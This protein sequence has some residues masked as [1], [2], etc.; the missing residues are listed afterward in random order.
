MCP[1]TG[2]SKSADVKSFAESV[3]FDIVRITSAKPFTE[4]EKTIR[5]RASKGFIPGDVGHWKDLRILQQP[6]FYSQPANALADA[7]SIV[8]LAVNYY[9]QGEKDANQPGNPCACIA[10][11]YWRCF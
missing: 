8:S 4:Y 5:N 2:E 1:K 11:S 6:R 10:R 7:K 9:L 3:G